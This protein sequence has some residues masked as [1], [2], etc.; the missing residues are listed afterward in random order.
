MLA[1]PAAE[2]AGWWAV[3]LP[4]GCLLRFQLLPAWGSVPRFHPSLAWAPARRWWAAAQ[5]VV[6]GLKALV[7][8]ACAAREAPGR[9]EG[10]RWRP[11]RCLL[12]VAGVRRSI[13]VTVS[14]SWRR[15]HPAAEC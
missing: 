6:R 14:L 2:L 15:A 9:G 7:A 1:Q 8:V 11:I 5:R 13:P 12:Q 10:H 3:P 4:A